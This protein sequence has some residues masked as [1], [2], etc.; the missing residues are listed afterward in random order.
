M[1]KSL[2]N[3]LITFLAIFLIF[4]GAFAM[5]YGIY[6]GYPSWI[7]W[8]CYIS[9]ILIGI[10]AL[11]KDS[12]LIAAQFNLLFFPL[13]FWNIDFFLV[14]FT[15][16]SYLGIAGYFFEEMLL[17]ARIIS[18]EHLFL[19]PLILYLLY[20]IKIK[21]KDILKS[22][23]I[24]IFQV[25]LIF[26]VMKI[27]NANIDNVNCVFE[28]CY[29][30]FTLLLPYAN[31]SVLWFLVYFIILFVANIVLYFVSDTIKLTRYDKK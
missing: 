3:K 12:L 30:F 28:N 7:F 19:I 20:L 14:L 8:F 21:K 23:I 16:N 9:M 2:K 10:G 13:L 17:P 5:L 31:Y 11:R 25:S 15:G 1:A 18:L 6:R 4:F 22:Y 27:L 29:S 26:A 24:S